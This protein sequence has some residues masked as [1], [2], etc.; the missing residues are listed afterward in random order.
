MFAAPGDTTTIYSH[1]LV[2]MT[3]YGNYDGQAVFPDGS[4]TYRKVIM[5]YTMGCAS[6]G[7]SD[8]DYTTQMFFRRPTGVFDSTFVRI[9]TI[10]MIPFVI[11]SVWN[12]YQI[13]ED[14]ELGRVITPYGTYMADNSNGYNNSWSHRH[15]FDVTDYVHLLQDTCNIRAHYSGWS[16]GF[17]VT[18]RFDFIEGTPPRDVISVHN[19]YKGSAGYSTSA[20][21]EST[22]FNAKTIAAPANA[23][24]ARI[25]STIT[26]HGFDN[27]VNC[28]EFCPRQY[29]VYCNSSNIGNAMIWKNDCGSNPIYPQGGTWIYDRAGWCP[30][31]KGNIHEFEW[32][33]F[34][35]GVNNTIDFNMQ[36][37]TWSGTQT[38][39]Y[40]VD[41]RVVFYGNNNFNNDAS[42]L[43]IIAPTTH[44]EHR[45]KNP[46]C[47]NPKILVKNLGATDLTSMV[48]E[49]GL[50]GAGTCTYT[51]TGNIPFLGEQEI[52]LPTLE[53][54]GANTAVPRFSVTIVSTNGVA[55]E[56]PHDNTMHSSYQVPVVHA[57]PFLLLGVQTNNYANE[58]SYS[59]KDHNGNVIIQ[60]LQGS[61]TAN[62]LYKDSIFLADG[63]YTLTVNDAGG[64]GLG[65]WANT[66]QGGGA[67]R[68]YSPFIT[69]VALKTFDVDFGNQ[70][71]YN[72]V[73]HNLDS[74]S[75][76]C[77]LLSGQQ[78]LASTDDFLCN[79]YPNPSSGIFNIE[80]GSTTI[81]DFTYNV[82]D[83][84]GHLVYQ[85]Q[86]AN[87]SYEVLQ[88]DL[89]DQAAGMYFLEVLGGNGVKRVE[90]LVKID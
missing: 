40:T 89:K 54:Q 36:N 8:W 76:A 30:G 39:S 83:V 5:T 84:M 45:R 42:L 52:D 68:F 9:D 81:Q 25:F 17:S 26:G 66:A 59:L 15:Y 23:T 16:S 69:F 32:I 47:G 63:C 41:A 70:L 75:S 57:W 6:G 28:A 1:N 64:D 46:F 33:G 88:I 27:N 60:R 62:T 4:K 31:S 80:I 56:F 77:S 53:W 24:K 48:I 73:W 38:P 90:K 79:F 72:F 78:E 55:D 82:Y 86:T 43:E 10:S 85:K 7:C 44:E 87:T 51:W 14:M 65:W 58:T 37:Y 12:V 20:N 50:N 21:F 11:D 34:N 35:A 22:F 49:Y 18:L 3:W 29:T 13:M 19:I 74:V 67:V 71:V 2:D 61:M